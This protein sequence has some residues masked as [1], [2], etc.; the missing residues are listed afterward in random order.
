MRKSTAAAGALLT[1]GA[2]FVPAAANAEEGGGPGSM[3]VAFVNANVVVTGAHRDQATVLGKYRCDGG[4]EGTHLWVSVKQGE[5]LEAEGSSQWA[6]AHYDTNYMWAQDPAGMT[7]DCDGKW[8]AERVTVK[9]TPASAGLLQRG[10]A[11]VQFCA[12]DNHGGFVSV[13]GYKDV[14]LG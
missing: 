10:S 14:R 1:L 12:F 2:A 13:N 5:N 4:R 11:W 9:M 6:T 8:H 3:E 7:L